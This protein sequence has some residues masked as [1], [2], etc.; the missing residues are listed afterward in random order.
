MYKYSVV[1]SLLLFSTGNYKK[2]NHYCLLRII[3]RQWD[4]INLESS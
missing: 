1:Y 3:L 2:P 4:A